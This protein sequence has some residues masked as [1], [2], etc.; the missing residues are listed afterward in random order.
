VLHFLIGIVDP[1]TGEVKP[2]TKKKR[3]T[4]TAVDISWLTANRIFY[5]ATYLFDY[6]NERHK[7][8]YATLSLSN[9]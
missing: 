6:T 8:D 1:I 5:G 9:D 2:T 4:L 3:N 7:M